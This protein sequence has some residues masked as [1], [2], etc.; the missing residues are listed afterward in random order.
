MKQLQLPL[1]RATLCAVTLG[2]AV[3][4]FQYF[5][6]ACDSYLSLFIF[7]IHLYQTLSFSLPAPF[8]E[9]GLIRDGV[10]CFCP[11]PWR[12]AAPHHVWVSPGS[13]GANIPP[14]TC[15]QLRQHPM[16]QSLS[17]CLEKCQ[18]LLKESRC[19]S[20]KK[21]KYYFSISL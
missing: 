16:V 20:R 21:G 12:E 6:G 7:V 15:T 8:K 9:E 1:H 14:A 4:L 19:G 17:R 13:T 3:M 18:L 11:H 5:W 10:P 2:I